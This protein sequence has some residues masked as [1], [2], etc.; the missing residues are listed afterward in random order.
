MMFR[1]GLLL[2]IAALLAGC[3]AAP[4]QAAVSMGYGIFAEPGLRLGVAMSKLPQVDTSFP[5]ADWP[6]SRAA[7]TVANAALTA[8]TRTLAAEELLRMKAEIA[9]ALKLRGQLPVVIDEPIVLDQLPKASGKGRN[10]AARNYA[11]LQS[12][13]Q[14]DKLLVVELTEIGITRPYSSYIPTGEPKGIVSGAVYIVNFK[15]N[16]YE[17][18]QPVMQQKSALGNWD[19]APAFPGLSNAFYQ[20]LDGAREAILRALAR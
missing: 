11:S 6:L 17:W 20:A 12:R 3:A 18:Y 16:T 2:A 7:A 4:P 13:Y 14:L 19:E 1:F 8:H 10:A 15:D 9:E 5:G